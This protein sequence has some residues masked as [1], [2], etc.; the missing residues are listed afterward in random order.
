MF[1][2]ELSEPS[3]RNTICNQ[4]ERIY[5]FI[6][7]INNE[8]PFTSKNWYDTT[9]LNSTRNYIRIKVMG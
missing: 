5:N 8:D 6:P 2:A 3:S 4:P 1:I 9:A 7:Q